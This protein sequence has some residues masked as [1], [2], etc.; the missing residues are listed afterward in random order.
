MGI[1]NAADICNWSDVLS[2]GCNKVPNTKCSGSDCN[3]MA[4]HDCLNSLCGRCCK[5]SGLWCD[6]HVNL[7]PARY[8]T[9]RAHDLVKPRVNL[10]RKE[11]LDCF[12]ETK[13]EAQAVCFGSEFSVSDNDVIKVIDLCKRL[14]VL[15]LG[16]S[17][18]GCG[19]DITDKLLDY[20]VQNCPRLCKLRFESALNVTDEAVLKVMK[21]CH[22]L[23]SLEVSGNDKI[24]GKVTDRSL[25]VL[26]DQEILPKLKVLRLTDQHGIS[27]D[28]VMRLRRC[29]PNLEIT[30]GFTDSD[31]MAW[32]LILGMTGGS[33]GDG[34]F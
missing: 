28:V 18:S 3:N 12:L 34:L 8:Q 32:S 1:K 22:E 29:R 9:V 27:Y 30:A 14:V 15:E 17:D 19:C 20:V 24:S 21:H 31:S 10:A 11:D 2:N 16:S 26:F 5:Q 4:K 33:Y 25:K 7:F 23:E 13:E 6:V